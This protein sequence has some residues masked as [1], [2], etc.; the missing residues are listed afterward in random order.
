M[1]ASHLVLSLAISLPGAG[2]LGCG[3]GSA[4]PDAPPPV[5]A[6]MCAQTG[7]LNSTMV[8]DFSQ[9]QAQGAAPMAGAQLQVL[10]IVTTSSQRDRGF[11]IVQ[12]NNAGVFSSAAGKAGRFEKPPTPGS[13]PMDAD[14]SFGFAIDF[15]DGVT[16]NSNGTAS[17]NPRQV[18]L[19][20]TAGGTVRID[21]FTPGAM[22]GMTSTLGATITNAKFKGFNISNGVLDQAGN[23]CD[24][25]VQNF[26]FTGLSVKWQTAA[27]PPIAPPPAQ[28]EPVAR[29]AFAAR[30]VE[31][32]AVVSADFRIE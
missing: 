4:G 9:G 29:P 15:V 7:T 23:G 12:S 10:V 5:D 28:P 11:I 24:V 31:G 3:G 30:A 18:A 1:R 17:I 8:L 19:L 25:T 6:F 14:T 22:P 16:Q 20:D 27:F 13:Y 26:A 21:S 32:A 2:V